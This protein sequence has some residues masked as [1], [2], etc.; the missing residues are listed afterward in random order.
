MST[1]NTIHIF[2]FGDTQVIGEKKGTV[3]SDSLTKLLAF[4]NHVKTFKPED[5][6][7]TDYHVI[8]V[9]NGT[10]V[11]Y[12]GKG[13]E[14]KKDKTSFSVEVSKL[15]ASILNDFAAEAVASIPA[16]A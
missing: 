7:L 4:V 5:V 14:N 12:L 13:T 10:T 1:F 8:H 9:F 15:T 6:T 16:K 2:G 11:R 3:K